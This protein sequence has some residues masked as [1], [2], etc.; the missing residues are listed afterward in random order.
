MAGT[1]IGFLD[2]SK[3]GILR[4]GRPQGRKDAFKIGL[5]VG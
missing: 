4:F 5:R 1:C 2:F 3:K